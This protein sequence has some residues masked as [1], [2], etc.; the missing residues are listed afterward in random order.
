MAVYLGLLLFLMVLHLLVRSAVRDR[1]R[2]EAVL[3]A[4]G[5]LAIFL[6]LALKKDTVGTDIPG[7]KAQYLLSAAVDWKDFDF[8]YFEKGYILLMKLFS[9]A[10]IPF[11]VFCAAIYG[12]LCRAYYRFLRRY[13]EH[14]IL[15]LMM[16]VC[17]QFLVFHISGLRQT[18]AI[19][20]C[21]YAFLALDDGRKIR[22]LLLT[23][24]AVTF[25][26]SAL[27]FFAVY[28]IAA[29]KG[30]RLKP[31]V[32]ILLTAA[33]ILLRPLLWGLVNRYFREVDPTTDIALGGNLIFLAGMAVFLLY[34]QAATAAIPSPGCIGSRQGFFAH[35]AFAALLGDLALSGSVLLRCN[36][37]FTLFLLPGVPNAIARYDRRTRL[38]LELAFGGFLLILFY[39]Q[40]L[41]INQFDLLP[42]R[43]FWQ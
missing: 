5:L 9:K 22:S 28:V 19:A 21:I 20:V 4:L 17:Y 31:Q 23:G 38:V 39:T 15:S 12:L 10:G 13:S 24:L 2:Q 40:T 29:G 7:Y 32:S 35:M 27:I 11:G 37:Y 1:R 3:L 34:T 33:V 42:Y 25:H 41:S 6:L 16:L 43:F 8:V 36:M 14:V 26:Q 18:L 30:R